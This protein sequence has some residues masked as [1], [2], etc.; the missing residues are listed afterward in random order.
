VS[1]VLMSFVV[2][3]WILYQYRETLLTYPW[4]IRPGPLLLALGFYIIDLLLAV[5]AWTGLIG[6]L[7]GPLPF[8]EHLR[9][10]ALTQ[11]AGRIPGA[12]WH[13]VGR[14]VAYGQH[15]ISMRITGVASAIELML[16]VISGILSGLFIQPVL[17]ASTPFSLWLGIPVIGLGLVIVH[18]RVI[19][20]LLRR[21]GRGQDGIAWTFRDSIIGLFRYLLVWM[22]GGGIL[23]YVIIAL[24]PNPTVSF[25]SIV[26]MWGFSGG[27][28]VAL[29]LSPTGFGLREITL[30]ALLSTFMSPGLAI[31]IAIVMRI[32]LTICEVM[33]SF[34]AS[35]AAR[36]DVPKSGLAEQNRP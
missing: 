27:L 30:T 36:L 13:L 33:A 3:G 25:L 8:R 14:A 12:P 35:L 19:R 23:Y 11:I 32:F 5:W 16:T 18:P 22:V 21:L 7:T 10:Y 29:Q 31:V 17:Y 28:A 34:A 9:I 6:R 1:F 4:H 24:Q 2:L 20:W 15:A 26:G